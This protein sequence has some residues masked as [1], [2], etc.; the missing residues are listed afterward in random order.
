MI[1][2]LKR[3]RGWEPWPFKRSRSEAGGERVAVTFRTLRAE[4]LG[5][6]SLAATCLGRELKLEARA[7]APR[8]IVTLFHGTAAVK[9]DVPVGEQG[10]Q[11]ADVQLVVSPVQEEQLNRVRNT[12]LRLEPPVE[13]GEDWQVWDCVTSLTLNESLDVELPSA[14]QSLTFGTYFNESLAQARLPS[15]LQSL[16]FGVWFNQSLEN[17][18]LPSGLQNLTFGDHFDQS[19][20]HVTLPCGL[21]TLTFGGF[22]D[23][24]LEKVELPRGLQHLA[25]GYD[26]RSHDL[27]NM[28]L[29]SGLQSLTFGALFNRSLEKVT[30]PSGLRRLAFGHKFAQSLE[31]VTL[32]SDVQVIFRPYEAP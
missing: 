32:P 10:L 29:P 4:V 8:G 26:F 20:E 22:F 25:F 31:R 6:A 19:L 16:T 27:G 24:S 14:L 30:L 3:R 15:G 13:E 1:S 17:V 12:I 28:T 7:F 18:T 11:G 21:Q 2:T 5:G 23:Q 9:D